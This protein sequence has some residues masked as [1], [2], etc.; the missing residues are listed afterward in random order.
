MHELSIAAS[1]V[2]HSSAVVVDELTRRERYSSADVLECRF[3]S[4]KL[5]KFQK[6]C[7]IMQGRITGIRTGVTRLYVPPVSKVRYVEPSSVIIHNDAPHTSILRR[8]APS[9]SFYSWL[10]NDIF[11]YY[12]RRERNGL[13]SSYDGIICCSEYIRNVTIDRLARELHNRV[14]VVQNGVDLDQ[15]DSG[16]G[17]RRSKTTILYI[18]R[19][20]REKGVHVLIDAAI[21]LVH[22]GYDFNVVIVGRCGF[23]N[24]DE[25]STYELQL[26]EA[27]RNLNS[28]SFEPFARR[29]E[30]PRIMASADILVVPSVWPDPN[31]LVVKEGLA[32]GLAVVCSDIGGIPEIV[33]D[34]SCLF[35]PGDFGALSTKLRYL[36]DDL[37]H[38]RSLGTYNR[39]HVRKFSWDTQ[40]SMLTQMLR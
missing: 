40:Y 1:R 18:G 39:A 23:D 25:L 30:V 24:N 5:N 19:V 7:D 22:K 17:D 14:H 12:S 29:E 8:I 32:A 27:A 20:V 4:Y 35:P 3:K 2:G 16:L 10:N 33:P 26:R 21:D 38:M 6:I 34:N 37:Q 31:P 9:H 15:F 28:I 36:L 11:R 13:V